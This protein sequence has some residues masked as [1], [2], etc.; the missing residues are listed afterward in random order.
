MR[1]DMGAA[2][3][4]AL[5]QSLGEAI[6]RGDR[7]ESVRLA[8]DAVEREGVPIPA[9]HAI[10]S[11]VLSGIGAAWRDGSVTVWQEHRASA[12]VR[13]VIEALYPAVLARA[14]APNG[15]T[16]VLACPE[17]EA[18]DLGLR[19]LSDRFELAGWAVCYLGADVPA[20]EI[21]SAA[22]AVGAEL[23]VLSAST[24]F[25]L[26]RLNTVLETLE[27]EIPGVRVLVGGPALCGTVSGTLAAHL[28]DPSEFFGT[29]DG[30]APRCDEEA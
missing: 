10:L 11:G 29:A 21:A 18:H 2:P 1:A 26:M 19:M 15:R 3:G 12:A 5:G 24:H 8:S 17:D 30:L 9:V 22:T 27:R 23:V 25:H 6:V 4:E 16:A 20:A 7:A 14:A 28:F 13:S